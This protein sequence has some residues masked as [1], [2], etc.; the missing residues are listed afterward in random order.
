MLILIHIHLSPENAA[1]MLKT[2]SE[3]VQESSDLR[4]ALGSLDN[5]EP[6]VIF[7]ETEDRDR[8]NVVTFLRW[9]HGLLH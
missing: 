9:V 5:A 3:P 1:A 4:T 2:P 6:V 7:E 8:A